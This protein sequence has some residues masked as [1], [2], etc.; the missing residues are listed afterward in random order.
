MNEQ[1]NLFEQLQ[2]PRN[3]REARF[4]RFH[5]ENPIVYRLWDRFTH[6]ALAKGHSRVGSQMIMERI[7]WETN[8]ELIDARPDN[9]QLKIN[10]HHAPYYARLWMDKNPEHKGLFST[11]TVEGDND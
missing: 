3:E 9:K 2:L 7:R 10:D 6:E 8:V 5:S 11:R 4:M 1:P